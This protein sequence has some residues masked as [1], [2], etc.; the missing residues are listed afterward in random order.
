[1]IAMQRCRLPTEGPPLPLGEGWGEGKP[2]RVPNSRSQRFPG[3]PSPRPSPGGRGGLLSRLLEIMS[4]DPL[5]PLTLYNAMMQVFCTIDD[6]R[7]PLS[8]ILWISDLPHFCGNAECEREG[9]YEIRLEQNETIWANLQEHDAAVE[10]LGTWLK[11]SPAQKRS[12]G[13]TVM[14]TFEDGRF[15]WRETYFVLFPAEKQPTLKAVQKTLAAINKNYVL[16]HPGCDAHGRFES[17][18]LISP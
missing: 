17:I 8:R 11:H 3:F 4:L 12:L 18:T 14:S 6:K 2:E 7:I 13:V 16:S 9:Q 1:M 15:R 5:S 10:A